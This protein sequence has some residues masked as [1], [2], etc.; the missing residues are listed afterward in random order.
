MLPLARFVEPAVTEPGGP[1]GTRP[2]DLQVGR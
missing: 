2:A 1:L